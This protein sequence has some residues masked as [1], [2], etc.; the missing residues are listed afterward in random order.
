VLA[1]QV[2][3]A[4]LATRVA[5]GGRE[6]AVALAAFEHAPDAYP[7]RAR[8]C[9]LI[10]RLEPPFRQRGLQS[11]SRLLS[12]GSEAQGEDTDPGAPAAC[13]AAL[14]T[15]PETLADDERDALSLIQRAL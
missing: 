13:R 5:E 1:R 10:P 14:Q 6:G 9:G 12:A 3:A 11:L 2:G 8:L 15:L 7:E 4:E